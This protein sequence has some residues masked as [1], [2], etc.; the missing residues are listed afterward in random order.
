M[1]ICESIAP[2]EAP[3]TDLKESS[4][5]EE[6]QC[7]DGI[8]VSTKDTGGGSM[9]ESSS[10]PFSIIDY[11]SN[12]VIVTFTNTWKDSLNDIELSFNRGDE[13]VRGQSL[14]SLPMEHM[15]PN[16]LAVTCD[17]ITNTTEIKV[18][19]SDI[20]GQCKDTGVGLCSYVYNISCS[21]DAV[22]GDNDRRL[23]SDNEGL[24]ENDAIMTNEHGLEAS[25]E[26]EDT[27]YCVHEDYPCKGDEENMVYVCHYSS[28]AGY[29]TF[30]IPEMDSDILRFNKNHQCGP[31]DGW[32]GVEHTGRVN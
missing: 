11:K 3:M 13:E 5:L 16:A 1:P 32:N 4:A 6:P 7:H 29:Q 24:V 21:V 10:Q 17:P 23:I 12:Q 19:I 9:C 18:C 8:L 15:Y 30:C 28:R 20:D 25:D 14:N 31:C 22:C 2:S 27:P 26:L